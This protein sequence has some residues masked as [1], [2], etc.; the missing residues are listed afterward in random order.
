MIDEHLLRTG[1]S[2]C[3]DPAGREIPCAGSAQDAEHLI[4]PPWPE[5]R[6]AVDW[7]LV[8]DRLMGVIWTGDADQAKFPV[9]WH[10]SSFIREKILGFPPEVPGAVRPAPSA[11][12]PAVIHSCHRIVRHPP[13]VH[14]AGTIELPVSTSSSGIPMVPAGVS[15]KICFRLRSPMA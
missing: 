12:A 13:H 15:A 8:T 5:P 2:R 1:R 14:H 10:G 11:I 3:Y 6:F 4:G 7:E 9:G